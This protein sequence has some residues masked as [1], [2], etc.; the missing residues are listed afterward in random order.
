MVLKLRSLRGS[1]S[2]TALSQS[3]RSG[4]ETANLTEANLEYAGLNPT[5]VV[6][7]HM[8]GGDGP[9]WMLSLNPTVVVLKLVYA[10]SNSRR[11][12][13]LNPTVVVLKPTF[14]GNGNGTRTGLNPTV[15]VLKRITT[16]C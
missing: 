9:A 1:T 10:F 12:I 5:V 8:F 2:A 13:C 11:V 15:V 6:L 14:E 7:K 3:N 16:G 4:F